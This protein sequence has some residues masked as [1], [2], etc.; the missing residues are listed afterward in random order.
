MREI[1]TR[2]KQLGTGTALIGGLIIA[3]LAFSAG[4]V[5]ARSHK[6]VES[7]AVRR[8]RPHSPPGPTRA[9]PAGSARSDQDLSD[10]KVP[11]HSEPDLQLD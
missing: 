8:R 1:E 4:A 7:P 3:A 11:G 9:S 10:R 6:A 5:G 2:G